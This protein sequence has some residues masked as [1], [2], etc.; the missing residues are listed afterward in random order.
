MNT[1]IETTLA[2]LPPA[3]LSTASTCE[4]TCFTCASKLLAMSAPA[5][6]RVAVCPATQTILPPSVITP[7]EKAR[8]SW[9]GV[10]S[11]YS[12]AVA[13]MGNAS[14]NASMVLFIGVSLFI[15][16]GMQRDAVA[17]AVEHDGAEAVRSDALDRMQ[18][19]PAVLFGLLQ[20]IADAPIDVHI[21]EDAGGADL[22]GVR[23]QAAAV[24]GRAVLEHGEGEVAGLG[25]LD[26]D[27]E[28]GAIELARAREL[29]HR[30]IEPHDAVGAGVHFTH[31]ASFFQ[32]KRWIARCTTGA[33]TTLTEMM[34][35]R[36]Q[37]SAYRPANTLPPS[38]C[39][40]STGPMP[41]SSIAELRKASRQ[42][43]SSKCS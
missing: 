14:S 42:A 28:D 5:L 10:F 6:S 33:S 31:R 15:A 22:L 18:H 19:A 34:T 9:N 30:Q 20:R 35:T 2:R 29:G 32:W 43:R 12:A 25:L 3:R 8:D 17:F 27:A 36:P 41:P 38:V 40:A 11:M 24:A 1:V 23:D 26:L 21:D 16:A 7:G 4:N 39:G 37:K 13:A